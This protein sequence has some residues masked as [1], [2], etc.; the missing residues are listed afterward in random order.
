[1]FW[2]R[3]K[4]YNFQLHSLNVTSKSHTLNIGQYLVHSE[5]ITAD[6]SILNFMAEGAMHHHYG[7]RYQSHQNAGAQWLSG[8]VLDSRLRGRWFEPHR[9]H[10]VSSVVSLSR[11]INPSLVLVQPRKTR[12]FITER[13]LMGRKESNQT[14]K[15][16]P[17]CIMI[18][19]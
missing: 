15:Q 3:K 16:T 6:T 19:P 14:N 7:K 2:F 9:H 12:P 17:E 4:K 1:M 13:L 10:C 5:R 18:I 8:R 11:N